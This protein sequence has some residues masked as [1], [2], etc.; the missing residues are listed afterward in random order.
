[1]DVTNVNAMT[2]TQAMAYFD[3][4]KNGSIDA[5]DMKTLSGGDNI[6]NATEMS[7]MFEKLSGQKNTFGSYASMNSSDLLT[8]LNLNADTKTDA[9]DL[10]A[11][12]GDNDKIDANPLLTLFN[13]TTEVSATTTKIKKLEVQPQNFLIQQQIKRLKTDQEQQIKEARLMTLSQVTMEN[14]DLAIAA[15]NNS[16]NTAYPGVLPGTKV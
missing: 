7:T 16:I 5:N 3:V 6:F 4:D 12:A 11:L 1:M 8:T 9:T 13:K 14:H 10:K 2:T 15:Y